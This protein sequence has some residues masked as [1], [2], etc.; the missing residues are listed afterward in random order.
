MNAYTTNAKKLG[1]T[2]SSFGYFD[3]TLNSLNNEVIDGI[4]EAVSAYID[5]EKIDTVFTNH[6]GDLHSDHKKLSEMVRIICRPSSSNVKALYE[7]YVPGAAEY[8]EGVQEFRTVVDTTEYRAVSD[9]CAKE[10]GS[11]MKNA[12]SMDGIWNSSQYFGSLNGFKFA[13]I[14]KCIFNKDMI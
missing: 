4:K 6:G 2:Y 14:F 7:C 11:L 8:G 9:A 13:E 3:L 12:T 10:Y 5:N 1:L